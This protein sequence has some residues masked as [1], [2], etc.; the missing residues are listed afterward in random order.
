MRVSS[1]SRLALA[2]TLL[3]SARSA[4]AQDAPTLRWSDGARDPAAALLGLNHDDDNDDGVPDLFAERVRPEDDNDLVAVEVTGLT[5]GALRVD[6]GG[7]ARVLDG[8]RLGTH[9][10]VAAPGGRARF[11]L[12]G[13]EASRTRDD[14]FVAVEGGGFTRRVAL[15]IGAVAVL[16]GENSVRLGH[17]DAVAV[18]HE[19]THN[20]TLPRNARWAQGSPDRENLRAEVWLPGVTGHGTTLIEAWATEVSATARVEAAQRRGVV[21]FREQLAGPAGEPSRTGFVRLVGDDIDLRA[22][23][24][25]SQTLLVALRDRLVVR[26]SV[27]GVAGS[28]STDLRV[29]RPGNEEGPLAA[30]RAVWRVRVLRHLAA[31]AGGLPVVGDTEA[32]A[33]DIGRRQITLANEIY[34]QCGVTLGRPDAADVAVVDPPP[35][36]VLS[37]SDDHGLHAEGGTVRLRVNGRNL[38][39]V[40]VPPQSDAVST[41][42]ALARALEASGFRAVV[43][44][45]AMTDYGAD[46]SADVVVRD[47]RGA[48][49]NLGPQGAAPLSTDRSQRIDIGQVDLRDGLTEFNNLSSTAGTLEE[50]SLLRALLDDDP[51]TIEI[52]LINRF[53]RGSRIGEAFV[54]GD[55]GALVNALLLD[56]TGIAAEREAWTQ[57]HEAGHIFLNEPWHPDNLGPDRPWLLMDSDASLG[58]VTG[59]KRLT[60]EECAHLR[61]RSGP[62]APVALLRRFDPR[63]VS[64]RAPRYV[65]W[66]EAPLWPHAAPAVEGAPGAAT[67]PEPPTPREASALGFGLVRD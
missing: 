16:D 15:T 44:V 39:P 60:V 30:R 6:T 64:G 23:G 19:I 22:P 54:E 20:A 13:V 14:S 56:R 42:L 57:A 9:A 31:A 45:N 65:A 38:A 3:V 61:E 36:A 2:V 17:R 35:R 1:P 49:A 29:G 25:E 26:H 12:T 59:P 27:E 50:R 40:A 55:G 24:V 21:T 7:G 32:R 33:L 10:I 48:L 28:L 11:W 52:V 47:A 66:P 51:T 8:E 41:A 5:T 67:R 34:L 46:H 43:S 58:A 62:G 63:A 37:V 53:G 18:S 4:R